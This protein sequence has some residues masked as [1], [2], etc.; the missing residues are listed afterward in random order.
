[1][2]QPESKR[3]SLFWRLLPSY[4]L[5]IVVGAVTTFLAGQALSPFF[6]ERHISGMMRNM[7]GAGFDTMT[8]AMT[9]D[10]NEAYRRALRQ[11]LI[12]AA[13]T[14]MVVAA[15]VSLYLT[16][17]IVSPLRAL[18]LASQRIAGGS[19]SAR[20][21]SNAPGEVGDL[22][23][24][25]NKMA[26]DLEHTEEQRVTLLGD[27]AHEI[28]TPLSN[29]KGYVEG[30]EDGVFPNNE[31]TL[32][33]CKRQIERLERLTAD[34]SLLSR[35][36]TG[37]LQMRPTIVSAQ[38]L[39]ER[40][41]EAFRPNYEAKGVRLDLLVRPTD[42]KV[43]ADEERTVQALS[44]LLSNA[45]RYTPTG[46]RVTVRAVSSEGPFVRFEVE[47][48]GPGISEVDLPHL[49]KRFYRGDKARSHGTGEGSGV[50]LTLVKQLVERQGGQVGARSQNGSG[51][52]FW[53]TLPREDQTGSLFQAGSPDG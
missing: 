35:V 2:K 38:Q 36:E 4:L 8:Q 42:A 26:A 49:F 37:Q 24:A 7:H 52:L 17:L 23:Q 10:L 6:L 15:F 51:A 20:L 33:A 14:S 21:D 5:I 44:N 9:T 25:F 47:D 32:S 34:L 16:R 27:V 19:Y 3:P 53:F 46:A 48:A 50:G 29:L 1:M 28:R 40:S 39:L 11:S 30:L 12:W 18:R 22:A 43:L 13:G 31:A 41:A 45:L